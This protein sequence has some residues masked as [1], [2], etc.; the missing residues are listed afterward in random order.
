A[1][2]TAHPA[3]NP[4][5]PRPT[6]AP[7]TTQ[8][9]APFPLDPHSLSRLLHPSSLPR[10]GL[11]R[12]LAAACYSSPPLRARW[13]DEWTGEVDDEGYSIQQIRAAPAQILSACAAP[14]PVLARLTRPSCA[15]RLH[16]ISGILAAAIDRGGR[17]DDDHDASDIPDRR[18]DG[19]HESW[20]RKR[21]QGRR[22]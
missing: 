2:R 1:P 18:R 17:R 16:L 11:P 8:T 3:A 9:L 22:S 5:S 14:N 4:S 21:G 10:H 20:P 6:P 13:R 12:S 15:A 7:A 19:R